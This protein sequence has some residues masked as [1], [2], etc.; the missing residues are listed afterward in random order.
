MSDAAA[1]AIHESAHAIASC[2]FNLKLVS[3]SIQRSIIAQRDGT[4]ARFAGLTELS[5]SEDA[6]SFA[7]VCLAGPAASKRFG[8]EDESGMK[9]DFRG[10]DDGIDRATGELRSFPS[11]GAY[12]RRRA[13]LTLHVRAEAE[14]IVEERWREIDTIALQ[15]LQRQSLDGAEVKRLFNSS[16]RSRGAK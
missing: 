8:D 12:A 2:L 6:V 16:L 7:I 13:A 3:V 14:R 11:I 4:W 5:S 15:L 9:G 1:V 10:A